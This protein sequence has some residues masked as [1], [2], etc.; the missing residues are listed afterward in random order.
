MA[1]K[2]KSSIKRENVWLGLIALSPITAILGVYNHS[3]TLL[4]FIF[5]IIGIKG[6]MYDVL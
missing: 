2:A 4:G 5:L 6:V 1:K 3:L